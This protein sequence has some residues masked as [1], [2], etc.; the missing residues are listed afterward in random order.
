M[1]LKKQR[2]AR[3]KKGGISAVCGIFLRLIVRFLPQTVFFLLAESNII[4]KVEK[5]IG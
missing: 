3:R 4:Q 1:K 2:T 5:N